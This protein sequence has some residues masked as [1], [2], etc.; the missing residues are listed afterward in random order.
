MA[1]YIAKNLVKAGLAD[2]CQVGISYAIG[3]AEPLA[4]SVESFG[5]SSFS[6]EELAE[7][8]TKVFDLRPAAIIEQLDLKKP[9]YKK[10]SAYGHFNSADFPWEKT[11]RVSELLTSIG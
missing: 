3:K 5:T 8:V 7:I 10:T 1:R 11:D 9:I 6:D 4:A 2:R